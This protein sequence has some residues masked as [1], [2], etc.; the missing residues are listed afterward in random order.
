MINARC[1]F[2]AV[3]DLCGEEGA[4]CA[5]HSDAVEN[6][7]QLGWTFQYLKYRGEWCDMCS[8]CSDI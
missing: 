4:E 5:T 7:R 6:A 2:V 1:K 3:C 8:D